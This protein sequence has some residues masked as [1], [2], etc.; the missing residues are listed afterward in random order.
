MKVICSLEDSD[1]KRIRNDKEVRDSGN[2]I[3][4][5]REMISSNVTPVVFEVSLF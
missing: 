1:E 4:K 2:Q 5:F 3:S